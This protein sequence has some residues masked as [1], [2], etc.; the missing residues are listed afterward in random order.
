MAFSKFL[1]LSNTGN[2]ELMDFTVD[3]N[4][5]SVSSSKVLGESRSRDE[6]KSNHFNKPPIASRT[7]K[8]SLF[9]ER[10]E[11]KRGN[12]TSLKDLSEEKSALQ[13]L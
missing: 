4:Q 10:T 6:V 12:E 7:R 2:S 3:S 5:E 11:E 9:V 1:R 8:K 13:V